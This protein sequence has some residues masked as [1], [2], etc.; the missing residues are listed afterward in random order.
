MKGE[1]D[2]NTIII[3]DVNIPLST[4]DRLY[5]EKNQN[6]NSGLGNTGLKLYFRPM[7]LL[8]IYI[9]FYPTAEYTLFSNPRGS[10]SQ[11]I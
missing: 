8:S 5:Q 11:I 9:T 1:T 10:F 4:I 2:N 7:D 6:G 3:G